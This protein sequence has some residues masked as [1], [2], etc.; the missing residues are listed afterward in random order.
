ME[1]MDGTSIT[2]TLESE[3]KN[4]K[5]LYLV[6]KRLFDIIVSGISLIILAPVFLLI[7]IMIKIDSKGKVF[8]KHKRIGKNGKKITN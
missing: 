4:K 1:E 2:A 5:V 6:V 8:Y 3:V 7:G